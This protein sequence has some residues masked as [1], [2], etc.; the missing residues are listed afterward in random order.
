MVK[1]L[2]GSQ[3]TGVRFP[4]GPPS[5]TRST[6][7]WAYGSMVEQGIRIAQIRVRFS[8]GP[9]FVFTLGLWKG[10]E[11]SMSKAIKG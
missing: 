3:V 6:L 5:L 10:R 9:Q 11:Q 8:V 2:A 1:L 4:S 7:P